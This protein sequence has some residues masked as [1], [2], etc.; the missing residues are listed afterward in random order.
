ML[1]NQISTVHTTQNNE[2]RHTTSRINTLGHLP[3]HLKTPGLENGHHSVRLRAAAS[4]TAFHNGQHIYFTPNNS[5]WKRWKAA[6]REGWP[7][8][9]DGNSRRYEKE[10]LPHSPLKIRRINVCFRAGFVSFDN[11]ASAQA[12]IQAMNGFQIGMKRLKVQLK[13]PKDA[14]RPY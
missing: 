10:E 8:W 12:A 13:R 4:R 3:Q 5:T 1:H 11:P 6:K 7:G 14:N 9:F 2:K